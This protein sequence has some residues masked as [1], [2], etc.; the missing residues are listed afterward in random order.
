MDLSLFNYVCHAQQ[1]RSYLDMS[2]INENFDEYI[3]CAVSRGR[4]SKLRKQNVSISY[5]QI[6]ENFIQVLKATCLKW[7]EY[8]SNSL[9]SGGA[10]L[11]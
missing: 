6:R 3:F 11:A 7:N 5:T 8:G 9:R 10:S 4:K 2:K 1:R